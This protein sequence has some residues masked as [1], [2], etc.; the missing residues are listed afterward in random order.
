MIATFFTKSNPIHYILAFIYLMLLFYIK[1]SHDFPALLSLPLLLLSTFFVNFIIS[2]N[3]LNKNNNFGIVA[4]CFFIGLLIEDLQ[5]YD[6][7]ISNIFLLLAIRRIYSIRTPLNINKKV[8]D[9]AF[10]ILMSSIFYTP[11][12]LFF[13]LLLITLLLY[14]HF[15]LN[16][17]LIIIFAIISG[18]SFIY[19]LEIINS[20]YF[21][22]FEFIKISLFEITTNGIYLLSFNDNSFIDFKWS[23]KIAIL[24]VFLT[25]F[26]SLYMWNGFVKTN[27]RRRSI[28]LV[29]LTT[30]LSL[31]IVLNNLNST[32]FVFLL[33]PVIVVFT[34]YL[35]RSKSSIIK[36]LILSLSL[37]L[38]YL[39]VIF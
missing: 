7:L 26:I 11:I 8:Y 29:F 10:W 38:P 35:E 22:L 28:T 16:T 34:S 5:S 32:T 17:I 23:F 37:I 36:N 30:A 14:S 3:T 39:S 20:G 21:S 1:G 2:K 19:F 27:E 13:I 12:L 4:I 31:I 6:L 25:F 24:L 15:N 9:A 18:A 33:L